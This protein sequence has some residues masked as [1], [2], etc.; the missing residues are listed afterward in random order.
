[1]SLRLRILLAFVLVL[2]S[3]SA[4]GLALAGV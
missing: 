4:G 2:V 1:M 3:G